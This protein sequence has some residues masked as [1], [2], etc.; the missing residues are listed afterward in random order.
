MRLGE[1]SQVRFGLGPMPDT[2]LCGLYKVR[3]HILSPTYQG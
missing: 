2:H 1:E 3:F